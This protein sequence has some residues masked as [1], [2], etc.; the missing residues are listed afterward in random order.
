MAKKVLTNAVITINSI[1]LSDHIEKV[2]LEQN[3]D[4]VPTTA[5][6]DTYVTRIGGVGDGTISLDFHQDYADASVYHTLHALRGGTTA[7]LI[8]HDGTTEDTDNPSWAF[9]A[10]VNDLPYLDAAHGDLNGVS[11]T[12]PISG[13]VTE[14]LS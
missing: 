12:W 4:D 5:F 9:T 11:V 3:W 8:N 7:L 10:L 13:D 2:T 1:D 14:A 6:G